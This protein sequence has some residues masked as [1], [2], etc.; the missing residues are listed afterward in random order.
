MLPE[1]AHAEAETGTAF[2][3]GG[4]VPRE[5]PD[6][7]ATDHPAVLDIDVVGDRVLA[8]VEKGDVSVVVEAPAGISAE[9]L[10]RTLSGVPE[11]IERTTE[12]FAETTTMSANTTEIDGSTEVEEAPE[13][14]VGGGA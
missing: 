1:T 7:A 4:T 9:E 2:T 8:S 11:S 3:D 6:T 5:T 10:E 13:D 12:R 14:D